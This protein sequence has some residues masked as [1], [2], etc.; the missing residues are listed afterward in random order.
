VTRAA[1]IGWKAGHELGFVVADDNDWPKQ[2]YARV[3]FMPI[4]WTWAIHRTG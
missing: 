3:G 1:Y 4:G 2:L